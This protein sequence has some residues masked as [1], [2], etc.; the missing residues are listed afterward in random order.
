MTG[1][2]VS[3]CSHGWGLDV[4][5]VAVS[6]SPPQAKSAPLPQWG[7]ITFLA[8]PMIDSTTRN[9]GQVLRSAYRSSRGVPPGIECN[10]RFAL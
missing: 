9:C 8:L 5:V 4:V 10:R 2:I 1:T 6:L 3:H 7:I